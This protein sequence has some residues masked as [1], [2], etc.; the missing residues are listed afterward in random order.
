MAIISNKIPA[1][2]V[3]FSELIT[4]PSSDLIPII[5]AVTIGFFEGAEDK[6]P[7]VIKSSGLNKVGFTM[8]CYQQLIYLY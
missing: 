2:L 1:D 7:I 6:I 5:L 4:F 8:F 3:S